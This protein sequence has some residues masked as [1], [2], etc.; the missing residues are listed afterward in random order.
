LY[1]LELKYEGLPPSVNK[2]YFHRGGRR[3]LSASGREFKTRFISSGG[4]ASKLDLMNLSLDVT[5]KYCLILMFFIK[6]K[7]LVNASF[8]TS[9]RAKY[10]YKALDTTNLVKVTEDAIQE[11]LGIPDQNNFLHLQRKVAI[12]DDEDEY[13]TGFLG[14]VGDAKTNDALRRAIEW[15][16]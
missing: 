15:K 11:L 3:I 6:K 7:R 8:G 10:Q 9:L 1:H 13:M 5:A 14:P 2:L 12:P 16:N 4:G